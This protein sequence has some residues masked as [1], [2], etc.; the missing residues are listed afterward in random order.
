M[1]TGSIKSHEKLSSFFKGDLQP[2]NLSAIQALPLQPCFCQMKNHGLYFCCIL[3]FSCKTLSCLLLGW[4]NTL[5]RNCLFFM[6]YN[7]K[8]YHF[9]LAI[10]LGNNFADIEC[11]YNL[12]LSRKGLQNKSSE[13]KE[14]SKKGNIS[15]FSLQ[16]IKLY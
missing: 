14:N 12:V 16:K 7:G 2:T 5:P 6:S 15:S 11:M 1:V 8:K 3:I 4:Q 13:R 9:F 10:P